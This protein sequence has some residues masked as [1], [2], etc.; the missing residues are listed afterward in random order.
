[1][2][3]RPRVDADLD[4]CVAVAHAV[5]ELD[6]YPA[7]LATD[8]RTFLVS[9]GAHA[10]WVAERSGEIVGHVALH[11]SSTAAAMARASEALDLPA[12]RLGVVARLLVAPTARRGGVGRALL[13]VAT[14]GAT[15]RGLWPVLDVAVQLPGAVRLYESR[16]WTPAGPVTVSF[17]DGT[18]LDELVFL[19]P[20]PATEGQ[21]RQGTRTVSVADTPPR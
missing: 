13:E 15:E 9:P 6:G 7:Y 14:H 4:V 16:G 10:A 1:V 2:V 11:R 3:V 21:R 18:T 19:G 17:P 8:L 5:H 20:P 12:D